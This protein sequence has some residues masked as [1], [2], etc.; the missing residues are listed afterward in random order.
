MK[1]RITLSTSEQRRLLYVALTRPILKLYVP[2]VQVG[3][4][5]RQFAGPVG[6]VLLP[7]LQESAA[8]DRSGR[9]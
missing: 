6:T 3:P 2:W 5:S 7:A 8:T 4:R 1:D 9:P